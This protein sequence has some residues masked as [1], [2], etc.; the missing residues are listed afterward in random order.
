VIPLVSLVREVF[1]QFTLSLIPSSLLQTQLMLHYRR[2][3]SAMILMIWSI[4]NL[5]GLISVFLLLPWC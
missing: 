3:A 5:F 1:Y 2:S 4:E